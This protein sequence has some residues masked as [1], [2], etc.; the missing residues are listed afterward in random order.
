MRTRLVLYKAVKLTFLDTTNRHMCITLASKHFCVCENGLFAM[1]PFHVRSIRRRGVS[2]T[3]SMERGVIT[4][5]P[6]IHSLITLAPASST[7]G[8]QVHGSNGFLV[9]L[10]QETVEI[11]SFLRAI[12]SKKLD[13][14]IYKG[15]DQ[16]KVK[17]FKQSWQSSEQE[18]VHSG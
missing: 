10:C 18:D 6:T 1:S 5:L 11:D 12:G 7:D 13:R 15:R 17:H 8:V 2:R 4:S 9:Y 16:R 14:G 3:S